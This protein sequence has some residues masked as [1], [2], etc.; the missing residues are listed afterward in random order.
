MIDPKVQNIPIPGVFEEMWHSGLQNQS[1][2][3]VFQDSR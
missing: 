3:T 1:A 2:S